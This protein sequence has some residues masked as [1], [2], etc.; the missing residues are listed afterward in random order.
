MQQFFIVLASVIIGIALRSC[1]TLFLRKLGALTFLVSS[2]LTFYF[3]FDSYFMG[4]LGGAL[5]FFLP[6]V[7]LLTRIRTLRLP[8]N[9]RLKFKNAPSHHHFPNASET[10]REIEDADY[11][12]ITDSG[13]EWVGMQQFSRLYW[14][15]E[16][17]FIASVCLCEFDNVAFAFMT[18]SCR[19]TDGKSIH[20]TNYPFSPTLQHSPKTHWEHLPCEKN[21]F[22][23]IYEDHSRHL[24]RLGL[25]DN[26]LLIP[27]PDEVVNQIESDM[28]EQIDHNLQ[29]GLITLTGDGHFRYSL[30]GLF[31]LWKQSV[32]DMIRLC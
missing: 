9:F 16:H 4:I 11:E 13:W 28:R 21:R 27:D 12:H 14:H 2:F 19:T 7:D 1:R 3:V 29:V 6:W 31:F 22:S 26:D 25:G 5:W 24:K 32:K 15:A 10:V 8:L 30:R 20:T 23:M 17:K 18:V